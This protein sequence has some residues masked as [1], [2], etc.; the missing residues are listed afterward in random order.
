MELIDIH[1][2]QKKEGRTIINCYPSDFYPQEGLWYSV[3]IHP[4]YVSDVSSTNDNDFRNLEKAVVHPQVLA[5]GECGLD[6]RCDKDLDLQIKIFEQQIKLSEKIRKPMILH[7]VHAYNEVITLYKKYSPHQS[8]IIHG[9][10]GKAEITKQL[11]KEGFYFSVGEHY[12][13]QSLSVIPIDRL[14]IETDESALPLDTIYSNVAKCL[15]IPMKQLVESVNRNS[16]L[17][18]K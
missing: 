12:S 5:L 8:W 2:H 3:G 9:F 17:F 15:S 18:W 13:Q 7:V 1:T 4:W 6:K 11:L 16:F 10:R 14:F